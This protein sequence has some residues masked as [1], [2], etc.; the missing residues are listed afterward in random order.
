MP[1]KNYE[2][3]CSTVQALASLG[4]IE[5]VIPL[6]HGPQPCLYQNQVASMSCRPAQLVTAGTLVNKS[7]V[8]FGGEAS[9][10][11]QV[12]NLY[13]KYHP[14]VIVIITTCIPQLIGED[15]EGVIAELKKEIP[16]LTVT[17]CKT[18][19][20]YPRSMPL[21]S[22][23]AW[24]AVL[25]SFSL[26]DKIPGAIGIVGR[27]GQDAGN[28]APIEMYFKKAGLTFF[29]FPTPHIDTMAD[30]VRAER[31]YP[32]HITPWLTCKRLSESF[33]CDVHY[34]E[35]PAGIEGTSRFLRGIADREHCQKLH[36]LVDQEEQRVRPMLDAIRKQFAREK[37]RMLL[38]TGP[39]NEVSIGK[40]LAEFGA[41]VFIVPCMKNKFYQIEKKILQNRY[42]I[43]FIEDD[44]D[45]LGDLIDE[46]QPTAVSIEFQAQP[47]TVARFI[48]TFINMLYLVEYGYDYALDLGTNFFKNMHRPVYETWKNFVRKYGG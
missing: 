38:V 10:K 46:I 44:F 19:F 31:V 26:Q 34:L 21:G 33:S 22:D 30:I 42:N 28:L 37:V 25:E 1:L 15:V 32:I 9:L 17:T 14:K 8:I 45:T 2:H 13:E 12:K 41:E 16:E 40:I 36:D 6:L 20:N 5:G 24:V 11:Q 29:S 7:E 35:I 27:T 48:P 23:A 4:K 47:E 39:A 18:G 3:C 43:R